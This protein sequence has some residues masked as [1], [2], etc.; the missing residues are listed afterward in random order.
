MTLVLPNGLAFSQ[1]ECLHLVSGIDTFKSAPSNSTTEATLTKGL[2]IGFD[3]G[4]IK[5]KGQ[6]AKELL[7]E[8]PLQKG[9]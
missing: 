7:Q 4:S 2:I 9:M 3:D 1:K 8:K 5:V 6:I